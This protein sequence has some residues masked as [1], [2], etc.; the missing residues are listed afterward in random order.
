MLFLFLSF[1]ELVLLL[2]GVMLPLAKIEEF[3]FF[4]SEFSIF[5]IVDD[6]AKNR[7]LALAIAVFSFGFL[8][9]ILKICSR[10]TNIKI[11]E[12]YNL[13]KFSMV[14]IFLLS[15]LIF[16]SKVSNFFEMELLLGFYFLFA[17]VLLGYLQII[18]WKIVQQEV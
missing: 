15:F 4:T 7:E 8:F 12:K 18:F 5:S 3:W 11:V 16:A 2:C 1:I 9:P 14:D 10:H 6:L 17:S 13:H